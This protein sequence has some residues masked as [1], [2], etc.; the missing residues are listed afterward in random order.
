MK[1]IGEP[2]A[3]E[4]DKFGNPVSMTWRGETRPIR[5]ILHSWQ[6]FHFSPLAHKKTWRT[7]RHRNH[8]QIEWEDGR[9]FEIYCD[10]GTKPGRKSWVL[11]Q[12]LDSES[13]GHDADIRRDFQDKKG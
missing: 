3:V 2:A 12:E 13:A 11:L 9:I 8:Y 7:R 5:R 1:F 6:D 4:C 10:R